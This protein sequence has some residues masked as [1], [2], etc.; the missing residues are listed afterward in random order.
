MLI[1]Y[2]PALRRRSIA[3][4]VDLRRRRHA[5][6]LRFRRRRRWSGAESDKALADSVKAAGNVI[7][8][9]RRVVRRRASSD[10][11]A[12]PDT[13][14][15]LDVAG[16]RRAARRLAAV[17][18]RWPRPRPGSGTTCSSSIPTVR[19]ATR[20]RSCARSIACCRRSASRRRCASPA[21]AAQMSRLDGGPAAHRRSRRCRC[22][23]R[24][25]QSA[26]DGVLEL[27]VGPDRLPR[28]GAARRS[29]EPH[30]IRPTRSSICSIPRSRSCRAEAERRSG[31]LPR[32][33]RVR[34][35]HRGR[36]VRR[37]RDAVRRTA[38]CPASRFTRRSP[39]T[40]CPTASSAAARRASASR[41]SSP[42]RWRR[43]WSR[44]LLPA[45]WASRGD[46]GVRRGAS[47][48]VATRLFGGGLLAEPVAA[49][50]RVVAR[51][52]R[53]RRLPVLLRRPREAE[54]EE[55]VRPVRLEGRLRAAGREPG[56]GA[57]RRPAARD[58]RAVLGHPRL[59][60]R[61]PSAGSRKR[62]SAC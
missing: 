56:A 59:H 36:P 52:V 5:A 25:V 15:P 2:L 38:R 4:D 27:S 7:L 13:G 34:R 57:A 44:P 21:S 6:R 53:R 39:T 62:S 61:V 51:A 29:E 50:P 60:D 26:E 43:R 58:D 20:F 16:H 46:R 55:A 22:R 35:H 8:R 3:Y 45:W 47:S 12:L 41:R 11:P 10:A 42:P 37:L 9:R 54:D 30:R 28:A 48:W 31:G 40:S 32:Q 23:W 1:D 49:G 19:C 33:D 18:R 17:P 14:F 24:R